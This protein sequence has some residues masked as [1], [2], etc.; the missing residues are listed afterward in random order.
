[1]NGIQILPNFGTQL[2][3]NTPEY[4]IYFYRSCIS[5][6]AYTRLLFS[7]PLAYT[8]QLSSPVTPEI[9]YLSAPQIL[10]SNRPPKLSPRSTVAP[11]WSTELTCNSK[12]LLC[13]H[14]F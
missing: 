4:L 9:V 14:F 13:T 6:C 8:E 2:V 1:M 11:N 5:A 12:L 7:C 10:A 3:Q